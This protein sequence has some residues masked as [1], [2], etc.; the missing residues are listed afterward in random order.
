MPSLVSE[1]EIERKEVPD[2]FSRGGKRVIVKAS[3]DLTDEGKKYYKDDA[4][5]ALS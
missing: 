3:L 2:V 4:A 5:K 1:K